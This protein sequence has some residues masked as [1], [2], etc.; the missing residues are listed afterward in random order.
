MWYRIKARLKKCKLLKPLIDFRRKRIDKK[1]I[2]ITHKYGYDINTLLNKTIGDELE[3]YAW[4]GTLLGV[5]RENSLIEYDNDMD[6]ALT[7]TDKSEWS[8][9]YNLLTNAGFAYHHHFEKDN[10][11]TEIAFR[12]KDVH[13][14]FFGMYKE[15]DVGKYWFCARLN[16]K[17][18]S[19]NEFTPVE[20]EFNYVEGVSKKTIKNTEFNVPNFYHEFLVANYGSNYMTPIKNVGVET[21][22]GKRVFMQNE[23]MLFTKNINKIME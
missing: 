16:D 22:C 14:D 19:E 10:A 18:Y 21:E 15:Q 8:K 5:V 6:Y 13:V 17:D 20:V 23:V 1:L 4:A 11:I 3:Y 7:I 2:K 12:Y 9:L